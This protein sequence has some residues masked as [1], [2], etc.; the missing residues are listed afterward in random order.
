MAR[1]YF[2]KKDP[3]AQIPEW[4]EMSGQ[5]FYQFAR[6]PEGRGRYFIDM[7]DVVIESPRA[8]YEEWHRETARRDYWERKAQKDNLT[9]LS[10]HSDAI[11]EIGTGEDVI[12]DDMVN[13]EEES[14]LRSEVKDLYSALALLDEAS[15]RLIHDLYLA[16]ERKSLRQLSKESNIP[17]MTLQDRKKKILLQLKK[18]LTRKNIK[19]SSVQ[20]HRNFA[21]E[22]EG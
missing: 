18:E 3:A 22:S 8:E 9:I 1:Q 13:V 21:I 6:S 2:R 14:I 15:Y 17:V 10:L 4:I 7:D 19:K 12:P 16:T 5:E 11:S 20:D